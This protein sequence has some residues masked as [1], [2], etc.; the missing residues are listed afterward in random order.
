[1]SQ[2]NILEAL[3]NRAALMSS[4]G[5]TLPVAFLEQPETFVSP[6]DGKYL[7]VDF[8]PNGTRW[9][10]LTSGKMV[11]GLLGVTV[12]WPKSQGAIAPNAKADAVAAH[13]NKGLV[14][15]VGGTRVK[16]NREPVINEPLSYPDKLSVPVNISWESQG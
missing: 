1:M 11:Q 9:E 6:E 13:F 3:L 12:V 8:F 14:L 16:I 4:Q 5:P 7:E 2:A 15:Q 10:G